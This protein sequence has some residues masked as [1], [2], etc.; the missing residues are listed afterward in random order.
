MAET[1]SSTAFR[2]I[3]ARLASGVVVVTAR[4]PEAVVGMT[5]TA[6]TSASLVP[7]LVLVCVDKEAS[8][9]DAIVAAAS[10]GVS[11]LDAGQTW[12]ARRFAQSDVD[13]FQ[14]VALRPEG[15]AQVPFIE[16]AIAYLECRRYALH[17]AGDHTIVVGEVVGG[18]VKGGTGSLPL[19]H[20]GRGFGGFVA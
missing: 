16:G 10:F 17:E 14:G 19:V 9:H 5:A 20:F 3:L 4:G 11:V 15:Q 1:I 12:I 6:F 18:S 2:E 7:P 13:R 8:A